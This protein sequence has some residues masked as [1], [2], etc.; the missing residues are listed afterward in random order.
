MV[1]WVLRRSMLNKNYSNILLTMGGF[2]CLPFVV[3]KPLTTI[4]PMKFKSFFILFVTVIISQS[5][6]AQGK[7]V[8]TITDKESGEA[9]MFANM[10][11]EGTNYGTTTDFNGNFSLIGVPAGTYS[12][13]VT[14]LSYADLIVPDLEVKDGE[15][16]K[17]NLQMVSS[18]VEI[19]EVTI[20]AKK[21]NNTEAAI[22]SN[23]KKSINISEGISGEEIKKL[24]AGN[25]AESVRSIT[26]TTIEGGKY[27]VVRGLGDRYSVT[28]LNN[29]TLP[30]ADPYR[31]STSL[32]LI[33]SAMIDNVE[34]I[35][36]FSPD[37][38]G[39]FTGGKVDITSKSY[40]EEFY[41]NFGVSMGYNT[42]SGFN[43]NFL[44]DQTS[45]KW[46]WLGI[47]DGSRAVP[48]SVL[49][50]REDMRNLTASDVRSPDDPDAIYKRNLIEETSNGFDNGYVGSTKTSL[51]NHGVNFSVGDEIDFL[52]G[53]LK[54]PLGFN[55]GVNYNRSFTHYS[56]GRYVL[57]DITDGNADRLNQEYSYSDTKSSENPQFGG[58]FSVAYRLA[59]H[60]HEISFT[61]IY[62]HD[63]AIV[64]QRYD[65]VWQ[66]TATDGFGSRITRFQERV[67][68]SSQMQ[69]KHVFRNFN[70]IKFDWV[71]SRTRSSQYLPNLKLFA[72]TY[73]ISTE[74]D[75]LYDMNRSLHE[76]PTT[77]FRDLTD[78]Q[79]NA[80]G[81]FEIPFK[82]ASIIDYLKTGFSFSTK[83]RLFI[84]D[85]YAHQSSGRVERTNWTSFSEADGNFME[86]FTYDNAGVVDAD[87]N[88]DG[89]IRRYH[90]GNYYADETQAENAY[91]GN[92]TIGAAYVMGVFDFSP[93][94]KVITGLRMETT[95]L[96]TQ[97]VFFDSLEYGNIQRV[98]FLPALNFIYKYSDFTNI[99]LSASQT[100]A[101]PNMREISQFASVGGIGI[102]IVLGNDQL[103]RTLIQNF[104]FRYETYPKPGEILAFSAYYKHFVNPIVWQLT[105]KASTPEIQP[106]NVDNAV[107]MGLEFEYR[108]DFGFISD[109]LKNLK[110]STNLS[111]IYSKVD[112][113]EEEI[114]QLEGS[115]RGG[116]DLTRP[117]QGQSPY[118]INVALSY[119]AP[120]LQWDNTISFNQWGDRLS[121][122]T[123]ALQPDVYEASRPNLNFVSRKKVGD[124]SLSFK[125]NNLLNMDYRKIQTY[126][127]VDYVYES[128]RLGRTFSL[129]V[130][131]GLT[132]KKS[133][134]DI[135]TN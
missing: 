67:I 131:Y 63:A 96:S 28:Q 111:Y 15:T 47:D 107:V 126:N 22:L 12:L 59:E 102:P 58:I 119:A 124:F 89:S 7:V 72:Y 100:L 125:A 76:L 130:T 70:D 74:G 62:N 16:T 75:T 38:P 20:S 32:D 99:R 105:P 134:N 92:E 88:R 133:K 5:A 25:A 127:D 78:V 84:E 112:K 94:V 69:G 118:I 85:R 41:L 65:G 8:G 31:N 122:V 42:Q 49:N 29:V 6:F 115:N 79:Y 43:K 90:I 91:S 97:S 98:D 44:T 50:Y 135:P 19:G 68:N 4:K 2:K 120:E 24:G 83:N 10:I 37:Q 73:E 26:G 18:I 108:K 9:V 113:S 45:G 60:N 109:K 64:H 17:L 21:V 56:D 33:P 40:P 110:L 80:Q 101:R 34:T 66:E 86:Y 129:S 36:T 132:G 103:D 27:M 30:S 128:F 51:L 57:N 87:S 106:I 14:V 13:R 123:G 117:F 55:L 82:K 81:D 53:L 23:R 121:F 116:I 35:K 71:L 3:F 39:S 1:K 11:L 61:Q 54:R 46:D 95:S 114:E 77:F 48:S 52:P 104:D 93:K